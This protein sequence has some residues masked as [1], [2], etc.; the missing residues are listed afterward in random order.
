MPDPS[1]WALSSTASLDLF[2]PGLPSR[3][4]GSG[5]LPSANAMALDLDVTE[6]AGVRRKMV[7]YL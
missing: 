5:N 2:A 3:R 4:R 6:Q 1:Q 7:E